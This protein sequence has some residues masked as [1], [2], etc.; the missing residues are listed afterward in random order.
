MQHVLSIFL[1]LIIQFS[2]C[3]YKSSNSPKELSKKQV[4]SP[5]A[6]QGNVCNK[7]E[8]LLFS[9]VLTCLT[10]WFCH[11]I[12]DFTFRNQLCY[13]PLYREKWRQVGCILL[14][15]HR[16]TRVSRLS[17]KALQKIRRNIICKSDVF[18]IS[19][20][21]TANDKYHT[22]DIAFKS[23]DSSLLYL[24]KT[25][26]NRVCVPIIIQAFACKTKL[27]VPFGK[28]NKQE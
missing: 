15:L 28:N 14:F 24:K 20:I 10:V 23:V 4:Y 5:C 11:L 9:I 27:K 17:Q 25:F 18:G 12:K 6:L 3:V 22:S 16:S 26:G 19:I 7:S 2:S 8:V 13:V 21:K 1:D